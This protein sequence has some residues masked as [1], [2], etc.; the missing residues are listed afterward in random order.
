ML[1]SFHNEK[2]RKLYFNSSTN[3]ALVGNGT[4][5]MK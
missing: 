5:A 2:K 4:A 3:V 1:K